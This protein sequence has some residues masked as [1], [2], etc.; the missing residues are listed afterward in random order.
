MPV[1]HF[2]E[3]LLDRPIAY[4]RVFF[5]LT[6]SI[7]A[8]LMLSQAV[9]WSKRTKDEE[10]WFYKSRHEWRA[11]TGM[12][13]EEQEG[14]R[15]ILRQLGCWQEK[16]HGVPGRLFYRI[17]FNILYQKLWA[18]N[19]A[20]GGKPANLMAENPPTRERKTTQQAGGKPPSKQAKKPPTFITEI[21]AETTSEKQQKTRANGTAAAAAKS[22]FTETLIL[23]Y[24]D[25]VKPNNQTRNAG[26]AHKLWL[27]GSDDHLV[28]RWQ[29][30]RQQPV[31]TPKPPVVDLDVTL[32]TARSL[33]KFGIQKNWEREHLPV[34]I[35]ELSTDP[36][37]ADVVE[38]LKGL[39]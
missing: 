12:T 30:K 22:K 14:A 5:D 3:T 9:Y 19:E 6:D 27:T 7:K 39:L 11:E 38:Q 20:Q 21:T 31:V 16:L 26:L 32:Y 28:E 25:E 15:R 18:L 24:L 34:I 2:L 23:D 33:L 36:R 37:H 13:R 17:D 1:P 29:Q 10:G 35:A 4:H 8:A